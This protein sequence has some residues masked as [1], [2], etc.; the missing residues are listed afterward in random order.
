MLARLL[1]LSGEKIDLDRLF[2]WLSLSLPDG[3]IGNRGWPTIRNWL[4]G[5]P[6]AWKSLLSMGVRNC[7][8]L[9]DK[10]ESAGFWHC[11]H[12]EEYSRLVNATR[13][14]DLGL[15]CIDQAIIAEDQRIASWFLGKV[16]E[17][18][19][20]HR[21]NEGLSHDV[22]LKRLARHPGL[23]DIF[24][25]AHQNLQVQSSNL[26][27]QSSPRPDWHDHVKP[28]QA[29]FRQN[30]APSG[31][32]YQLAQV[33]LGGYSNVRGDTPRARLGMLLRGDNSLVKDILTGFRMATERNDLPSYKE[34]LRLGVRNRRHT[35]SYPIMAG[36][37]DISD[38]RQLDKIFEKELVVRLALAIHYT[39]PMWPT[40]RDPVDRPPFWFKWLLTTRPEVVADVLEKY[41][42]TRLRNRKEASALFDLANSE[43]HEKVARLATM[44]QL[45]KFPV[46]CTSDQ[47]SNLNYLLLSASKYCQPKV[48]LNLIDSKLAQSGMNIAQRIHWLTAG[49]YL[50]P[51]TYA[52]ELESYVTGKERRIRFLAESVTGR[53]Q[54]PHSIQ[55]C[56]NVPVLRLLIQLIGT[57]YRP[58]SLDDDS[59]EGVM[60]S[61]DMSAADQVKNYI[62]QLAAISSPD[63]TDAIQKLLSEENLRPWKSYLV[64]AAYQQ[65]AVYREAEFG[66]SDLGQVLETLDGK[67][68]ANAADL[69]AFTYEKL[70][71]IAND[72]RHGNAD[73]WLQYWNVDQ[74]KRP[75]RPRPEPACR[76]SLIGYLKPRLEP[77]GIDV[78]REGNYANEKQADIRVAYQGFNVPVEI[79]KSC[80]SDLERAIE[81]QL[82]AKYAIDP[83]AGRHGIYLVLWFGNAEHCKPRRISGSIPAG[84]VELEERLKSLLPNPENFRIQVC[85]IDVAKPNR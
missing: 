29:E 2:L 12:R 26:Q 11:M 16:A 76:D 8:N 24:D 33:Y 39:V 15:W 85:V 34:I 50:S 41:A 48:L 25:E 72:I 23:R 10:S 4:E 13:P 54:L 84:P 9:S 67:S 66:Y 30:R 80:S 69:A 68:P 71:E 44:P 37:E 79:K 74:Y 70:K 28:Y 64:D 58:Y 47:L 55:S 43:R 1:E 27:V 56:Q 57:S 38:P 83:G 32:L 18:L 31:L 78:L 21:G 5:H 19:Q 3:N 22:V 35:L 49:L 61:S 73:G 77:Y 6:T 17:C 40:M 52:Q 20:D 65:N 45:E 53:L 63:A 14:P 75:K 42:L 46:R 59:E 51:D 7:A 82:I 81:T 62:G 36:L 60:Y